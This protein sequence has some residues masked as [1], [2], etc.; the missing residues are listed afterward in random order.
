ML[1]SGANMVAL[2]ERLRKRSRVDTGNG[3]A[4]LLEEA[5]REIER[6]TVA[7]DEA[8]QRVIFELPYSSS[9]WADDA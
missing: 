4:E 3:I 2:I 6:L 5:A 8:R 7:L 1:P 9:N